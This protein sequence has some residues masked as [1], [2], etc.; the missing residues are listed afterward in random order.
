[1]PNHETR[2][3]VTCSVCVGKDETAVTV[4]DA[5]MHYWFHIYVDTSVICLLY[6]LRCHGVLVYTSIVII[7]KS[8]KTLVR[9]TSLVY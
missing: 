1:M 5:S 9:E 2:Y 6:N 4:A 8:C 7:Q 3:H